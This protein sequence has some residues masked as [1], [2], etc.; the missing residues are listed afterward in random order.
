MHQYKKAGLLYFFFFFLFFSLSS[1]NAFEILEPIENETYSLGILDLVLNESGSGYD[2]CY[3][4]YNFSVLKHNISC[5]DSEHR[6]T[7]PLDTNIRLFV[8][9]N[10]TTDQTEKN[11]TFVLNR[12]LTTG[13]GFI[14]FCLMLFPMVVVFLL[15]FFGSKLDDEHKPLKYFLYFSSMTFVFVSYYVNMYIIE[16]FIHSTVLMEVFSSRVYGWVYWVILGYFGVY[17]T[18]QLLLYMQKRRIEQIEY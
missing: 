8:V 4:Y 11:T 9:Y 5:V 3:Y 15:M 17:W 18:Y 1:V 10:G 6:I 2:W 16:N 14:L 13:K 12:A 7:V